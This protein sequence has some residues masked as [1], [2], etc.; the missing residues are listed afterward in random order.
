M[1][2]IGLPISE[3]NV[4]FKESSFSR[5]VNSRSKFCLNSVACSLR[6]FIRAEISLEGV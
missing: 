5:G 2:R 6:R 4:E 1:S 3:S